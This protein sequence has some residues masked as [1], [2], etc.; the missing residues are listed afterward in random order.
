MWEH[1][2]GRKYHKVVLLISRC[3][4][5]FQLLFYRFPTKKSLRLLPLTDNLSPQLGQDF[6]LT[7]AIVRPSEGENEGL[8][9]LTFPVYIPIFEREYPAE[10]PSPFTFSS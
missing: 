9:V 5:V 7:G 3:L 10:I 2:R 8:I 6:A 1:G 4:T